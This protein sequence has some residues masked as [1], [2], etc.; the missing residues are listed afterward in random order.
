MAQAGGGEGSG[1]KK[2]NRCKGK[3]KQLE[4]GGFLNG[5]LKPSIPHSPMPVKF[6][7]ITLKEIFDTFGSSLTHLLHIFQNI[8]RFVLPASN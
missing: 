3:W 2:V 6:I 8:D 4:D 7:N 5:G 1:I